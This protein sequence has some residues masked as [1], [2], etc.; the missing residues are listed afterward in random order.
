MKTGLKPLHWL[1]LLVIVIVGA[2]IANL[3]QLKR[4]GCL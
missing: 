2:S 1:A 4:Q 3:V